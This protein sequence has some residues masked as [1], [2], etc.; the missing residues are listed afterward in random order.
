MTKKYILRP[1]RHQ[2]APGS[3]AEHHND[4]SSDE[5]IGW[6][7]KAYPHIAALLVEKLESCKGE[8]LEHEALPKKRLRKTRR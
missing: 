7:L 3:P 6:Y 4:N 2:F 1:G 8:K 5:E